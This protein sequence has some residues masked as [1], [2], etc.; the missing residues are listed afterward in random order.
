MKNMSDMQHMR[1]MQYGC[2]YVYVAIQ[3]KV[4]GA[5]LNRRQVCITFRVLVLRTCNPARR[6]APN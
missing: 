1:Y 4:L 6:A 2:K 5:F 3:H